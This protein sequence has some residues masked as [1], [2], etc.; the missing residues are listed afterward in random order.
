[1]SPK[2]GGMILTLNLKIDRQDDDI[3]FFNNS[4]QPKVI[5]ERTYQQTDKELHDS[6]DL[7]RVDSHQP[8]EAELAGNREEDMGIHHDRD[9]PV[10]DILEA[11]I[12]IR[13]GFPLIHP[14]RTLQDSRT[15][16][17]RSHLRRSFPFLLGVILND[18]GYNIW[19]V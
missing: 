9:I 10:E 5:S 12:R 15:G 1:M 13:P 3:E 4:T 11:D 18:E 14:C 2:R 16:L 19:N 6:R 17:C 7:R 8:R